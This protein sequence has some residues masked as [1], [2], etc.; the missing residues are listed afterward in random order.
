MN[1][2]SFDALNEAQAFALGQAIGGNPQNSVISNIPTFWFAI[3]HLTG[4]PT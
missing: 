2:T 3:K 1:I 4:V